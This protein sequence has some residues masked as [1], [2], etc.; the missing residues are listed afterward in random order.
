MKASQ[1]DKSP[2]LVRL[3]FPPVKISSYLV[4]PCLSCLISRTYGRSFKCEGRGEREIFLRDPS[5]I[6]W[7]GLVVR[8]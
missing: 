3:P 4:C 8:L 2:S 5:G 1:V 6:T 7:G